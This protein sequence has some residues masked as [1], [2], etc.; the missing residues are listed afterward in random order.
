MGQN[1]APNGISLFECSEEQWM[2]CLKST[3]RAGFLIKKHTLGWMGVY[4]VFGP[5][6]V[7]DTAATC[8]RPD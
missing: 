2:I 3:R 5:P 8:F 4:E 7:R 6:E 1:K